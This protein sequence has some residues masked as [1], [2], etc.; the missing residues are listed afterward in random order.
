VTILTSKVQTS[1]VPET[2]TE[3]IPVT[4][5]RQVVKEQGCYVT[6]AIPVTTTV[7]VAGC[8]GGYTT[9]T[10]CSYQQVYVSRPVICSV[11]ETTYVSQTK[12]RLVPV[13]Q[14]VQV[15]ETQ[16]QLVPVTVNDVVSEQQVQEI[17]VPV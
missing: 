6:Q 16:T 7:P 2:Y 3:S 12:T 13:Q 5:T 9:Q 17:D 15:P 1:M 11:P 14:V 8:A 10:S 4:T